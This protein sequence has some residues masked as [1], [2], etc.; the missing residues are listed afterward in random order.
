MPNERGKMK[1]REETL[2]RERK[3]MSEKDGKSGGKH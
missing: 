1:V 2:K 3:G